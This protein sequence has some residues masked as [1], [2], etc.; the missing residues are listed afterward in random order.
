MGNAGNQPLLTIALPTYNAGH[1]ALEFTEHV[2]QCQ[3]DETEIEILVSENCSNKNQ[4][5]YEI[6]KKIS[7][8]RLKYMESETPLLFHGNFLKIMEHARG[9][10][11]HTMS[12]DDLVNLDC[13]P[14]VFD[15][16]KNSRYSMLIG[17]IPQNAYTY[18][19]IKGLVS[20]DQEMV[21]NKGTQA[22]FGAFTSLSAYMSH[23]ILNKDL[24]F[25]SNTDKFIKSHLKDSLLC[26]IYPSI[27]LCVL[28]AGLYGDIY[29]TNR[30]FFIKGRDEQSTI[31][32][33][34]VK[35]KGYHSP[36]GFITMLG[37][38]VDVLADHYLQ[39]RFSYNDFNQC[40][41]GVYLYQIGIH[42]HYW[43]VFNVDN[44]MF[45][46]LPG[47]ID[48]YVEECAART[49]KYGIPFS[50]ALESEMRNYYRRTVQVYQYERTKT[51]IPTLFSGV[52]VSA[53]AWYS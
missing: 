21:F 8:P 11:V 26:R 4:E 12:N 46:R 23:F 10:F 9:N 29:S 19:G 40:L 45:Y 49:A 41:F 7:D 53:P 22:I 50:S 35:G 48:G 51:A 13:L 20:N 5:P 37:D 3:Y 34:E 2:L 42:F 32:L 47:A 39:D 25:S 44:D 6:I 28:I 38:A 15:K 27:N 18:Y 52:A 43:H 14:W 30:A 16:I 1:R 24:Y 36:E 31:G 17:C 33:N